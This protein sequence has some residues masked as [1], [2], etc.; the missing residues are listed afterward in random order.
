MYSSGSYVWNIFSKSS[1]VPIPALYAASIFIILLFMFGCANK[2]TMYCCPRNILCS[3]F[4]ISISDISTL[5]SRATRFAVP[6]IIC[7]SPFAPA[8]DVAV[9][10]NPLSCFVIASNS[11]RSI[12]QPPIGSQSGNGYCA[13]YIISSSISRIPR[14]LI[15]LDAWIDV[16]ARPYAVATE[17][18][19]CSVRSETLGVIIYFKYCSA[20]S[21]CPTCNKPNAIFPYLVSRSSSISSSV[22][23]CSK[24]S[25][26]GVWP[27]IT[28]ANAP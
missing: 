5:F 17:L 27:N 15:K 6:G 13:E 28:D 18:M 23:S 25:Y 19:A 21:F 10:R 20:R 4:D 7:I 12:D 16:R 8:P 3:G 1:M 24:N 26:F 11:A 9:V 22:I 2:S 14:S